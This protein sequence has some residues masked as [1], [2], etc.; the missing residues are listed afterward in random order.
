MHKVKLNV[1]DAAP[2]FITSTQQVYNN[3]GGYFKC[4]S[5]PDRRTTPFCPCAWARIWENKNC[6]WLGWLH[7]WWI[8]DLRSNESLS[9]KEAV[10]SFLLPRPF[11]FF[12]SLSG[13]EPF[14]P[15]PFFFC[16]C[17]PVAPTL[18]SKAWRPLRLLVFEEKKTKKTWQSS[19]ATLCS[20][21]NSAVATIYIPKHF[22]LKKTKHVVAT[23]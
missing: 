16:S 19:L 4:S 18:C 17:S 13:V 6:T 20:K 12:R 8:E 2:G 11:Y 21:C 14:F 15:F 10:D 23:I 3:R 7:A 22:F 9:S 5:K 1:D